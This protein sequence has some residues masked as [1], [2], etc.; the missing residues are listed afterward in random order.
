MSEKRVTGIRGLD[1]TL[2]EQIQ[3]LAR[4][5]DKNISEVVN[6]AL[7]RLLENDEGSDFQA[8][9]VISGQDRFE[10]TAEALEV[11]KPL[12]IK[13]V[14]S[15]IILDENNKLSLELLK[16]NL[17]SIINCKEVYVP[18][19]LYYTILKKTNNVKDIIRYEK[20]WKEEKTLQFNSN[21]RIN[22]KFL[23]RFKRENLRL[24]IIVYEDLFLDPDIT[25]ELFE[26]IVISIKC[27][28]NLAVSEDLYPTMMT[29]GTVEGIVQL[30]D[31]QGQ[32]ID[33][34]QFAR[35]FFHE[36]DNKRGR[37]DRRSRH[38]PKG[39]FHFD[40]EPAIEGVIET[41]ESLAE[42]K[43]LKSVVQEGIKDILKKVNS[44]KNDIDINID[45]SD[46]IRKKSLK[47]KR[48]KPTNINSHKIE[49]EDANS[50][51]SDSDN[52]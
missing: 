16:N 22:L 40:F 41:L 31:N 49:I 30:L 32:P 11:L 28:G 44:E 17:E 14:R 25:Q 21:T 3:E 19:K 23:Q 48:V 29:I 33:Q 43:D 35:E 51:D 34:V 38:Q 37:K 20:P 24:R 12:R 52:Y 50:N 18:S 45:L 27:H 26:E 8:P 6:L 7:R 42:M 46:E 9:E 10:L 36:K 15:V 4:R 5:Q 1:L 13:D 39:S 47:K 2:Y